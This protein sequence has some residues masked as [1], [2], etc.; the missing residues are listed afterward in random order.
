VSSRR[1]GITRRAFAAGVALLA[2]GIAR[3]ATRSAFSKIESQLGGRIGFSALDTQSGR[4]IHWRAD[5][6]FAMCSTFKVALVAAVLARIDRGTLAP[7]RMLAFDPAHLLGA[8][9]TTAQ[10][11]DGHISVSD[12]CEGAI[13]VSDNTAANALLE[14]IGGPPVVTAYFRSLGDKVS[15]LDRIETE[16]NSNIE[17][18][19]RDTTSPDAMV[20]TLQALLLGN[21]LKESS[22]TLLTQWMQNEQNGRSRARAGLPATWRVAN[23]PGTSTNGAVNDIAVTWPPQGEPVVLAAYTNA[24]GVKTAA[25]ET[26]IAQLAALAV[27]EFERT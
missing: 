8:S 7:D 9:R 15:R 20:H 24:P 3:A 12:A 5:E 25:S 27:R 17:G 26:A 19:V 4:R 6:R 10:H 23:K 16:L 11:P 21:V 13:S 2:A 22:R 14:L 1:P 18:D